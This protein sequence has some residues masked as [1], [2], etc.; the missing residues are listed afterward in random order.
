[1]EDIHSG[2]LC[3]HLAL[4][5]RCLGIV[6]MEDNILLDTLSVAAERAV[7]DVSDELIGS[8]LTEIANVLFC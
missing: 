1:M 2:A 8:M 7:A 4:R 6:S 3:G 5:Q